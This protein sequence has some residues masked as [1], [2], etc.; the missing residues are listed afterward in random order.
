M[1]VARV[2]PTPLA[3][4]KIVCIMTTFPHPVVLQTRDRF[5]ISHLGASVLESLLVGAAGLFWVVTLV[6]AAAFCGALG[7]YDSV[8]TF[9]STSLRLPGL[10]SQLA[11]SPLLLRRHRSAP[12]KATSRTNDRAQ[13]A[14]E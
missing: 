9:K 10:R 6:L 14:Q 12:I 7:V 5:E 1:L 8:L 11:I 2:D 4:V 3:A 13:V